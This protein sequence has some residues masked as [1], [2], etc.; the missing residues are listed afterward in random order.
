[1][2]EVRRERAAAV[3]VPAP[4]HRVPVAVHQRAGAVA[5]LA[6][7]RV[8]VLVHERMDDAHLDRVAMRVVDLLDRREPIRD[9]RVAG[10]ARLGVHQLDVAARLRVDQ[11]AAGVPAVVGEARS[12]EIHVPRSG[13]TDLPLVSGAERLVATTA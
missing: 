8:L 6:H 11:D 7:Q 9:A 4:G 1:M 10:V 3:E 2:P 5:D 12:D 13:R